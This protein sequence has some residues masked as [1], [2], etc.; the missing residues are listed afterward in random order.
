MGMIH[1]IHTGAELDVDYTVYGYRGS[2]NNYNHV[3]F[4]GDRRTCTMCHLEDT[5]NVPLPEGAMEVTTERSY[6]S[7]TQPAAAACLACHSTVD[8]AAHAYTQTA[9]FGESCGSCHGEDRE[10]SVESAHAH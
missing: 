9:P 10:F 3:E 5:Y 6:Y 7:P 1:R 2:V 4:P 8:A